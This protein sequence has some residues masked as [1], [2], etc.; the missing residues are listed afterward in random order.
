VSD[1]IQ[2][3]QAEYDKLLEEMGEVYLVRGYVQSEV[4]MV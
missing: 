1:W 2:N 4:L 3:N